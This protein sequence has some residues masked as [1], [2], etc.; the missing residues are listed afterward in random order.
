MKFENIYTCDVKK[1]FWNFKTNYFYAF[2]QLHKSTPQL[3]R[4]QLACL[5]Y[6][7]KLKQLISNKGNNIRFV[8]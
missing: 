3:A 6:E 2:S 5:D 4:T 8:E 7:H 1:S